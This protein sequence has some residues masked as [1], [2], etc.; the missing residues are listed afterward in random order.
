MLPSQDCFAK[1]DL[2]KGCRFIGE[3]SR[4][5][6]KFFSGSHHAGIDTSTP[7]SDQVVQL[8]PPHLSFPHPR[9]GSPT[10]IQNA[11]L[12]LAFHQR[13]RLLRLRSWYMGPDVELCSKS[14]VLFFPLLENRHGRCKSDPLVGQPRLRLGKRTNSL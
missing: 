14:E 7:A 2:L 6:G 11:A 3:P 4:G 5:A 9:G 1:L 10:C 8:L 13:R 12:D